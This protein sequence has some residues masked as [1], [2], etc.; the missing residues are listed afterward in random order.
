[1]KKERDTLE[2]LFR[3]KLQDFEVPPLPEDWDA[4]EARLP[5]PSI[6]PTRRNW[7]Y[8][9]AAAAVAALVVVSSGLYWRGQSETEMIAEEIE[10]QTQ[11]IPQPAQTV[12]PIRQEEPHESALL[13]QEV[14]YKTNAKQAK[15]AVAQQWITTESDNNQAENSMTVNEEFETTTEAPQEATV[16]S[17]PESLI[18]K[19]EKRAQ[20]DRQH[21]VSISKKKQQQ[22]KRWHLGMGAGSLSTIGTDG[23]S[24]DMTSNNMNDVTFRDAPLVMSGNANLL[25]AAAPDELETKYNVNHKRP[26]T[27]GLSVGYPLTDRLSLQTGLSYS[28]LA[29]EWDSYT[30]KYNTEWRSENTQRLHFLG[31]PVS[32]AYKLAEWKKIRFYVSAG[33]KIEVG[34]AGQVKSDLFTSTNEKLNSVAK[35]ERM[36]EPYFSVNGHVG[37]SYPLLKFLSAYAEVGADYYF[38]NG[39]EIETYHS[40][41]PCN[42]GLQVGLRFGL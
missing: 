40:E 34:V 18:Q 13:A 17:E 2:D 42:I 36:K 3:S 20:P 23:F 8:W 9:A 26:L 27:F 14:S 39:S 30:W 12:E 19:E 1:M 28:Y 21:Y 11:N 7:Y 5:Q 37:A 15:Q 31:L 25:M 35:K 22:K 6:A 38:D 4:I 32:V 24:G 41:K 33:G 29:S 10:R 16:A